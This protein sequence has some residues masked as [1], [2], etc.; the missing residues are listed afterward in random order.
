MERLRWQAPRARNHRQVGAPGPPRQPLPL[1]VAHLQHLQARHPRSGGIRH[2][3]GIQQP[4][5]LPQPLR[6]S[7]DIEAWCD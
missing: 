4:G 2:R 5:R 3:P 6:V 1:S 7:G